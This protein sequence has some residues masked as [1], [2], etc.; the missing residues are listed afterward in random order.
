VVFGHSRQ[1]WG[2][3]V[4]PDEEMFATGGHDKYIALWRKHKMV[5][6]T[7]VNR[8]VKMPVP[9]RRV[10]AENSIKISV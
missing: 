7:Q 1:L 3:A 4:H 5:W 8:M 2:L 10:G 9:I 6:N